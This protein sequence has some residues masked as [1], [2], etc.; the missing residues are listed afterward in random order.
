MF[1]SQIILAKKGPLAKV[2]LAAHGWGDKKLGG[3][4]QI[5]ATDIAASVDS[6]VH[7]TVPLALRVSGHL[8][9]G[10]VRIY[11]KKVHY[12]LHDCQNAV[13][14]LKL[15]FRNNNNNTTEQVLVIDM[16]E[17]RR[18]KK[19]TQTAEDVVP[20][21]GEFTE[22]DD[23]PVMAGTFQVVAWN[24]E[25]VDQDDWVPAELGGDDEEED[26]EEDEGKEKASAPAS[27]S[28][29]RLSAGDEPLQRQPAEEEWTAFDPDDDEEEDDEERDK[30]KI[31]DDEDSKISDIEV[32]RAVNESINSEA[33]QTRDSV[34]EKSPP[35]PPLEDDDGGFMPPDSP[36][37]MMDD[38][39]AP[40]AVPMS[41]STKNSAGLSISRDE[42]AA[43]H[44]GLS[45]GGLNDDDSAASKKRK[46]DG[47]DEEDGAEKPKPKRRRKAKRKRHIVLNE[48]L[49]LSSA[50]IRAQLQDTSDIIRQDFVHPSTWVPGNE[51]E[52]R[53]HPNTE[54]LYATL[55]YERLF[56]RPSLGD[57]GHLAPEL[58]ELWGR[59]TAVVV[60]KPF[61][62]EL[63]NPDEQTEEARNARAD[64]ESEGQGSDRG[65]VMKGD[66]DGPPMPD[67]DEPPMIDDDEGPPIPDDDNNFDPAMDD[68]EEEERMEG[69]PDSPDSRDSALSFSLVNDLLGGKDD[70]EDNPRQTLGSDELTSS[71]AKWHKHTAQVFSLLKSRMSS[72][73]TVATSQEELTGG[74]EAAEKPSQLSYKSLSRGCTRR[75]AATVFLELLQLKTWDYVELEQDQTFGD[76][77]ILPGAKFDDDVP[78]K[79]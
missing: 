73:N 29:N 44:R 6:I 1:Y 38:D 48:Q 36:M 51:P 24:E 14:K 67:D 13:I 32:T 77:S 57:D 22:G 71:K 11:S 25:G 46:A 27:R 4:P 55:S 8:L 5:F 58:L 49:E 30:P 50:Q 23:A 2:W 7:P 52:K 59:H 76:I 34:L 12:L 31:A 63:R 15:A 45:I 20:H 65:D 69:I 56:T 74:A 43:D 17:R 42:S 60:G 28:A 75:T 66:D 79:G 21:F 9:W 37:A 41:E 78:T 26:E 16:D 72:G 3:R 39:D 18:K 40:Q 68:E 61:P 19:T 35:G 53:R 47:D 33:L 54:K 64:D 62:Y 70:D 10:V